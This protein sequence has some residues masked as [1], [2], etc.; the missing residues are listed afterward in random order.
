[1][2]ALTFKNMN[3]LLK[4]PSDYREGERYPVLLF[5]HGAGTRGSDINKLRES[6]FFKMT[7]PH[8]L[9]FVIFAPLY[10]SNYC[11]NSCVY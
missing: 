6:L 2:Q 7:E 5:L 3:Y 10:L 4:L 9:P 1:M 11:I 8:A